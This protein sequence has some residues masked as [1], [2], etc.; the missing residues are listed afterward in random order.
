MGKRY[1][2]CVRKV[3]KSSRK[4]NPYA[5]CSKLRARGRKKVIGVGVSA[6]HISAIIDGLHKQGYK[7]LQAVE[8]SSGFF[9]IFYKTFTK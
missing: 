5:V 3:K 8:K 4:V 9:D 6:K 2:R 1:D 7:G